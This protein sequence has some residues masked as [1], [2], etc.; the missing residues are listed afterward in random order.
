MSIIVPKDVAAVSN[1]TYVRINTKLS[2]YGF[3]SCAVLGS[4]IFKNSLSV[5]CNSCQRFRDLS[6]FLKVRI[7]E[8]FGLNRSFIH[9]PNQF[10]DLS[11]TFN[12]RL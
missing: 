7:S 8:V 4:D 9:L 6:L 5:C 1:D 11:P 3:Y 10:E 2:N 12:E